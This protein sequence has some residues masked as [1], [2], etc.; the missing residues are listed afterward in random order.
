MGKKDKTP[1]KGEKGTDLG[2]AQ[3]AGDFSIKPESVTPT[4]DTSKWPL[5]LKNYDKLNVRTGHYTP[6]PCGNSP[7]KRPLQEHIRY[8]VMNL[9]K[10]ANPSSHEV[11]AWLKRMLRVEKTGH[12][13]TLDPKVTGNLIVCIDRATRLVKSQQGAGKEY[14]CVAKLHNKVEGGKAKVAKALETLTGALFQR[15]PL[16]S[17]VKR[18][19]RI[20]TIYQSKLIEYDEERNLVLFW[21]SCEAGTYVRTLCVH[22]G[23]LLGVGGH[24]QE[25]RRVR[26]GIMGEEDN[27][28]TMHDILDA[29]WM[30]DNFK[31]ETYLRRTIMPLEVLLTNFKRVVVKDSAV[32][33]ICYGAKLMI[34]GLLRYENGIDVDDEVVL[35][36]TKGEAIAVG[37]AQMT[38]AVMATCDHGVVAKIK[39]V[40]MERDTYPRRWGL[41]PKAQMKKK[42][43]AD[44]KLDKYG[45]PNASTPAEYLKAVSSDVAA[46]AAASEEPKTPSSKM[47]TDEPKTPEAGSTE[48]KKKKKKKKREHSDSDSDE[49]KSEKK[50]KKKKKKSKH[51][52]SD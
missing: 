7:L 6:I 10:P 25:L 44:G 46:A 52:D 22:M 34:P 47:D 8:G 40:I 2:S 9:D 17:A 21:I 20:R 37:I 43:I 24:M 19:L 1:K 33:A 41:G 35:I 39:R 11:V 13:G 49:K 3:Q 45:R 50:K 15:P 16:I 18:Q 48:K 42:L 32:N 38:T 30:Y 14:V 31:D 26:S 23:L 51:S 4:L 29:M 36:T 12:S 28:V 5:L 27:M